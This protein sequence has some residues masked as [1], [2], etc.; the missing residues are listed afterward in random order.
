M[1][2]T[3]VSETAN[4]YLGVTFIYS[5]QRKAILAE[6]K[7]QVRGSVSATERPFGQAR[8]KASHRHFGLPGVK[9]HFAS[10][11]V[12]PRG[13]PCNGTEASEHTARLSLDTMSSTLFPQ[14]TLAACRAN[15]YPRKKRSSV[16]TAQCGFGSVYAAVACTMLH[17]A[18]TALSG[19]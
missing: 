1:S 11:N 9:V 8:S 2:A 5:G 4:T 15:A 19:Q 12:E 7:Q 17:G 6:C 16:L 3:I 13:A 18:D 14:Q 10:K